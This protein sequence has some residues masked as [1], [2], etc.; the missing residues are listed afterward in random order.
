[1]LLSLFLSF[2]A[3][4]AL[5]CVYNPVNCP[6]VICLPHIAILSAFGRETSLVNITGPRSIFS[7]L[8]TRSFTQ[9][10]FYFQLLSLSRVFDPL[11]TTRPERL[12]TSLNFVGSKVNCVVCRSA[13]GA[14][15]TPTYHRRSPTGRYSTSVS[16]PR[17]NCCYA[18]S[19]LPLGVTNEGRKAI[20]S[21]VSTANE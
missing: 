18:A 4:L 1:M 9:L 21:R 3:K 16:S 20:L 7:S 14:P 19:Y 17:K 13:S 8:F 6:S 11:Y 10:L 2:V 15:L 12:T 5:P